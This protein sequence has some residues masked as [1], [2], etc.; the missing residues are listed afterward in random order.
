MQFLFKYLMLSNILDLQ[1]TAGLEMY[2]LDF[3]IYCGI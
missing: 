3:E 2:F 1:H